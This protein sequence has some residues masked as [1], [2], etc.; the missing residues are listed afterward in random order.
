MIFMDPSLFVDWVQ[1]LLVNGL[2]FFVHG[3]RLSFLKTPCSPFKLWQDFLLDGCKLIVWTRARPLLE[4]IQAFF[5]GSTCFD[6]VFWMDLSD[7]MLYWLMVEITF[8]NGSELS[9]WMNFCVLFP[10]GFWFSGW[11]SSDTL[12]WRSQTFSCNGFKKRLRSH[13][14]R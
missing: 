13:A 4:W 9:G 6:H 5:Y 14:R 11:M 12:H 3:C 2:V 1:A 7:I 10:N 8:V